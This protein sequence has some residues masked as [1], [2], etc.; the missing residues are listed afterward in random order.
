MSISKTLS[1]SVAELK[2][3]HRLA[4]VE[5]RD[6]TER[7]QRRLAWLAWRIDVLRQVRGDKGRV[8]A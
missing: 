5:G 1:E 3:I 8:S 4:R 7:E 2:A 6:L